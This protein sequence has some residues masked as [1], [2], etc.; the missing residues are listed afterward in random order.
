MRPNFP[1]F[2]SH[3]DLTHQ[4]WKKLIQ[5]GDSVIDATCGNGKDTLCL[6]Q[7][8]LAEGKG[9]IYAMDIQKQALDSA[10]H[11]LSMHLSPQQFLDIEFIL[12][13]HSQFPVEIKPLTIKLIVY[14]LGYLPGGDKKQTTQME[15]TL[16]SLESAK[17]LI[18]PGGVLCITCYPGHDAGAIEEEGLMIFAANL[19]NT[20]WSCCHH[21]WLNREKSPSLLLLQKKMI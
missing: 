7:L 2:Q 10:R 4:Y 15:S 21:R 11:Y 3:L 18:A 9:I 19:P 16:K 5:Q 1:L 20:E 8:T 6:A 17:N 14:N 13:C 12:G